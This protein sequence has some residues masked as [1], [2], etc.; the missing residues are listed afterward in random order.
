MD[1]RDFIR[2]MNMCEDLGEEPNWEDLQS[3]KLAVK[4]IRGK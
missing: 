3:Y 1:I 4:M 2:Y